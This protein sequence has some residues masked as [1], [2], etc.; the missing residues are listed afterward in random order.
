MANLDFE[1]ALKVEVAAQD[2]DLRA[3]YELR[4][5]G[6]SDAVDEDRLERLEE[7]YSPSQMAQETRHIYGLTRSQ[8]SQALGF[9]VA[10]IAGVQVGRDFFR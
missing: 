10:S 8:Y 5:L 6:T 7:H 2:R 4:M 3:F 9:C 1:S